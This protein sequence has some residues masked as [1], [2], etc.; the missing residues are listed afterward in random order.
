[1]AFV[2]ST[3][4]LK[5]Q[6]GRFQRIKVVTRAAA[7]TE[8][9]VA[10]VA[11]A[12]E[13][14]VAAVAVV[15]V[16]AAVAVVVEVTEI[17]AEVDVGVVGGAMAS[18]AAVAEVVE[19][20]IELVAVV[21]KAMAAPVAGVALVAVALVAVVASEV[22]GIDKG[23]LN[24]QSGRRFLRGWI[25]GMGSV[26]C[27]AESSSPHGKTSNVTVKGERALHLVAS[28]YLQSLDLGQMSD[29]LPR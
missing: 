28:P 3:S 15:A 7:P 27:I 6:S 18:A 19:V 20:A 25:F 11:V 5:S 17:A 26:A 10:A 16:V 2:G 24:C 23:R 9:A 8:V 21:A 22:V 13:V 4:G 12:A 1:M 29:L 14:A